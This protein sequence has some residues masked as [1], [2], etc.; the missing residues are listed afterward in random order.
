MSASETAENVSAA[1]NGPSIDGVDI[2]DYVIEHIDE[3]IAKG[4]VRPYYQPVVR[5]LTGKLCGFEALARWDDPNYGLL[6]PFFFI[7]PLEHAQLIHLLD[8][9]IIR[10]VC[11]HYRE[12]VNLGKPVVPISFNLSRLDFD[13]C[14]I[15]A[16]VEQ[17][18]HEYEVPR[19][20]LNIE[21]TESTFAT[22][23]TF[24]TAM[25][26]KFRDAGYQVWMDDF[27]SGYSSLNTL[28]DF[29]FNELKIDM[30]FLSQFS[31]KSKT[32]LASVVDM[33]KKLGIQTLAEGVETEEH[34]NY[35]RRI[36]CEKMQGYLFGKPHPFDLNYDVDLYGS[37][38]I[39][40]TVERLYIGEVGAVNTLS[41]SE[42]NLTAGST[43]KGYVTSMPLATVEFY[44]GQFHIVDSNLVFLEG[45][46]NIGVNSI[47]EAERLV[48]DAR[49]PFARHVRQLIDTIGTD[50]YAHI[51]F[52]SGNVAAVIRAKHITT[53]N[54]RVAMLVSIDDIIEQSEKRRHSR[55]SEMLDVMYTVYEHVDLIHLDDNYSEH[56]FG[57]TNLHTD[58]ETQRFS[59]AIKQFAEKDIYPHDRVRYLEFMDRD[60]MIQRIDQ[61]GENF[62]SGFFRLRQQGGDYAWK[63]FGLIRMPDQTDNQIMM[64]IRNSHSGFDGVFQEVFDHTFDEGRRELD[65]ADFTI[66]DGSLWRAF[67]LDEGICMFWKDAERRFIGANRAFLD[68]YGF[69]S[70]DVILG[71]TDEDMGW[72]I[73]P[74]PFMDD[75]LRV[76]N[77]GA[78][79][80]DVQGHCIVHG[81]VH[82]IVANKRPIYRNGRIVGIVG[83]FA[84]IDEAEEDSEFGSM[85]MRDGLTG[86]LGY[87]GLESATWRFVDCYKRQGIDFAMISINIES[88][89]TIN[90]EF[91]FTFGEKVLKRVADELVDIAGHQRVVGHVFAERFVILA[92]DNSDEELQEICNA[93]ERRLMSI[94]HVDG[95]PCTIYALASYARFS[96]LGD[97]EAMKRYN[98]DQRLKRRD[99][100]LEGFDNEGIITS[101]LL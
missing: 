82:N 23:P 39:E 16:F 58:F 29:D 11:R 51:D 28:K 50:K 6:T 60:T 88:F 41:M 55:M 47:D 100:W 92:Q 71:K 25:M 7:P 93:I 37:I 65:E 96:K 57:T 56:I 68:Y 87:V 14:D 94:P 61:S 53:R 46:E 3:A 99:I 5:T 4:W 17:V 48:N 54:G 8:R 84:D 91:G 63:V 49:R 67:T 75:E 85:P 101:S 21:I 2:Y 31:D 27:G 72:H 74:V 30:E 97:V 13:L 83:Y 43:T 44:N 20:M 77:E 70:V 9:S 38:G 78:H 80:K 42:R 22:D 33:S 35:L 73:D 32:I 64:C 19:R 45:L 59:E 36:G 40:D 15:F 81:E 90:D 1:P 26:Q 66:T 89:Q 24:M 95:T 86:V 98:R 18:A 76:L 62:V 69:D 12:C 52:V 34:R 10:Q 79:I